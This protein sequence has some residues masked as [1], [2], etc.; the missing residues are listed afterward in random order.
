[1]G[2]E[3]TPSLKPKVEDDGM[4]GYKQSLDVIKGIG[5]E[6]AKFL[7]PTGILSWE[8][9]KNAYNEFIKEKT[10]FNGTMLVLAVG[11]VIPV[12]GKF[13][14]PIKSAAK[15]ANKIEEVGGLI[16]SLFKQFENILIP[17]NTSVLKKAQDIPSAGH[18]WNSNNA[19]LWGKP[20]GNKYNLDNIQQQPKSP[21]GGT[22]DSNNAGL[23]Q[24]QFQQQLVK[25]GINIDVLQDAFEK[26][27]SSANETQKQLARVVRQKHPNQQIPNMA[28]FSK[29][30]NSRWD[31]GPKW[32]WISYSEAEKAVNEMGKKLDSMTKN[33][34]F[35]PREIKVLDYNFF[36]S[37]DSSRQ[38]MELELPNGGKFL[39]YSSGSGTS[40]KREGAWYAVGGFADIERWPTNGRPN[41][42][43]LM[44]TKE[45]EYLTIGG[46]RY[47]TDLANYLE[48][49]GAAALTGDYKY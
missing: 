47:L 36:G 25:N 16:K 21:Q 38:I 10:P 22:Y 20:T 6:V 2:T 9:V 17:P 31:Y 43:W 29:T 11:S 37:V 35:D 48:H 41:K 24:N 39:M 27:I 15:A 3:T 19:Q 34:K 7:D 5:I 28:R 23:N 33:I 26:A 45:T 44:K 49:Y 46:N 12:G 13:V 32:G 40:N 4:G 8:D 30:I 1:M 18:S 14:Q 42:N